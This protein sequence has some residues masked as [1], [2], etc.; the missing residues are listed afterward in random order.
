MFPHA[1]PAI[2]KSSP[3]F[4]F[5]SSV[6]CWLHDGESLAWFGLF[7]VSTSATDPHHAVFH[8]LF[9]SARWSVD[10]VGLAL[11]DRILATMPDDST[12]CLVGDDTMLARS[13]LKVFGTGMHRDPILS[14]RGHFATR[15]GQCG[16]I[17][18]W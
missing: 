12:V 13:G 14:S 10:R 16:V 6:G 3:L 11:L 7:L 2:N 8:R 9:A 5:L 4:E 15:W 17:S 1:P 18:V